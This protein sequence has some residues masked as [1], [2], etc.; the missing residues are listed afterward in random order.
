M[1]MRKFTV[2]IISTLLLS[3]VLVSFAVW[4]AS[5]MFNSKELSKLE[6]IDMFS[7][8][9]P[10]DSLVLVLQERKIDHKDMP[11]GRY[12]GCIVRDIRRGIFINES[13]EIKI[14]YD[15]RRLITNIVRKSVF[16]GP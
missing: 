3:T 16:T 10:V 6:S 9:D 1:K 8:G 11:D 12:V 13:V 2:L 4:L 15:N 7:I 5:A 14:F